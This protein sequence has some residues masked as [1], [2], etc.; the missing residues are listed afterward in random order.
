MINTNEINK[1]IKEAQQS[2]DTFVVLN[3]LTS[4]RQLVEKYIVEESKKIK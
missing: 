4:L 2:K 1:H 3:A